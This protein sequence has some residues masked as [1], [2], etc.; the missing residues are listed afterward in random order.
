MGFDEILFANYQPV[1]VELVFDNVLD[2]IYNVE[3]PL[4]D[5]GYSYL[6]KTIDP[7]EYEVMK[8]DFI[9]DN[10]MEYKGECWMPKDYAEAEEIAEDDED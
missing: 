6:L 4:G 2:G 1:D 5:W 3:G 8:T 7:A 9:R 10:Y